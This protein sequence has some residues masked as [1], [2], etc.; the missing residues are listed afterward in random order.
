MAIEEEEGEGE[1]VMDDMMYRR[2]RVSVEILLMTASCTTEAIE[3]WLESSKAR[4]RR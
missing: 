3:I 1:E 2:S 4:R